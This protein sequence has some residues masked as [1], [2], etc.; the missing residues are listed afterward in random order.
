MC[1]SLCSG[2]LEGTECASETNGESNNPTN[3]H[4]H[5]NTKYTVPKLKFSYPEVVKPV[6]I[7]QK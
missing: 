5:R 4:F 6:C 7:S 1:E 2:S 3:M